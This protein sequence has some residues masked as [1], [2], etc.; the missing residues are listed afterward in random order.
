MAE[1]EKTIYFLRGVIRNSILGIV[2]DCIDFM[3]ECM[4]VDAYVTRC[5]LISFQTCQC[6]QRRPSDINELAKNDLEPTTCVVGFQWEVLC[7]I[8][9]RSNMPVTTSS[10]VN[11]LLTLRSNMPLSMTFLMTGI[12]RL[13]DRAAQITVPNLVLLIASRPIRKNVSHELDIII[14]FYNKYS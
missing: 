8:L 5:C 4:P 6:F 14:Y 2:E 1:I 13:S 3:K 7:Q 10:K 12:H 11:E 9:C